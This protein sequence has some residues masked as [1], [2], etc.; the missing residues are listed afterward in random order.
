MHRPEAIAI[1]CSSGGFNAL[2]IL[3]GALDQRLTQMIVL[4]CHTAG[5]I[6]TLCG[7]LASH[8]PL[9]VQEA[10]ERQPASGGI[11]HVAPGGYHLLLENDRHFALSVDERVHF[12]RP[13][14]DVLFNSIAVVYG[15]AAIGVILTGASCDGAAGLARRRTA[16]TRRWRCAWTR[17]S[18]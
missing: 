9:P 10:I 18:R 7:L 16:A 12:S 1:G 4:C 13:S 17:I 11:V 6:E 2:Q 3:L 8:G 15:A 5:D 14:I